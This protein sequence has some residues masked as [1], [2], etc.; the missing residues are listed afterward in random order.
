MKAITLDLGYFA[1]KIDR[2]SPEI[3]FLS[4]ASCLIL[5]QICVE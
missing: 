1:E 2:V 3:V 5:V 4:V